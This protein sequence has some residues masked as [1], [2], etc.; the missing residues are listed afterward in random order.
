M[1]PSGKAT[2]AAT[3]R[4]RGASGLIA[5]RGGTILRI[6]RIFRVRGRT[7]AYRRRS[8]KFP[9]LAANAEDCLCGQ[10]KFSRAISHSRR[11]NG[12]M[13]RFCEARRVTEKSK[14]LRCTSTRMR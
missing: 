11:Q 6:A 14:Y 12:T 3:L 5:V 13:E 9:Y 1:D 2:A 8:P 7:G 4:R 10:L